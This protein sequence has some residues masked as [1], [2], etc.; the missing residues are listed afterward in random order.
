MAIE[1]ER[2]YLYPKQFEAIYD[3]RPIVLIE[4]STKAGKTHGCLVWIFEH[5]FAGKPGDNVWWI[6]PV[7]DTADIAYRR[8]KAA[9]PQTLYKPNDT[10]KQMRLAN[11]VT[12]FFRGSDRPDTLYGEDVIAVVI[13]EGS[14]CREAAYHA[15]VSVLTAT[16]GPMRIIGNVKGRK[17]WFWRLCRRFQDNQDPEF[18]YY[19]ITWRDAVEAGV[20]DVKVI[21]RARRSLPAEIF[22]ELYECQATDSEGNPFAAAFKSALP[23]LSS[24]PPVAFG[25]DIAE[26]R[27]F[28]VG[29][30]LD[31]MGRPCRLHRWNKHH[32]PAQI[33]PGEGYWAYT[34]RLICE[35]SEG[36]PALLDLTGIGTSLL[37]HV[38]RHA[39][40][41]YGVSNFEG[42]IFSESSRQ[43]LLIDLALG[44]NSGQI[45]ATTGIMLSEL[46]TFGYEVRV[47]GGLEKIFYRAPEGQLTDCVMALALAA[48]SYTD[49]VVTIEEEEVS[50]A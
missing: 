24:L 34:E 14:R 28:T 45:V 12:M 50:V 16:K 27:A 31:A 41:R 44:F 49:E 2:P 4:A 35:L 15:M 40:K 6:A 39:I 21:D 22:E 23:S 38:E 30:G 43:D 3:P 48:R 46:S 33:I 42:F 26:T 17:N 29:V 37:E 47:S 36:R 11:G 5:A 7:S 20:L 32:P 1:F 9:L 18:G 25:W 10:K 13:D 8:A 19:R